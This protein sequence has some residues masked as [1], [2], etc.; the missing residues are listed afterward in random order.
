MNHR[1]ADFQSAALPLSYPGL[2]AEK[3]VATPRIGGVTKAFGR[4]SPEEKRIPERRSERPPAKQPRKIP[5]K[6]SSLADEPAPK[7]RQAV[8]RRQTEVPAETQNGII[9]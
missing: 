8:H 6:P 4:I 7:P 2:T 5:R 1:H 3:D 9:I